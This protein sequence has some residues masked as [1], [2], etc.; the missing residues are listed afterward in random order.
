MDVVDLSTSVYLQIDNRRMNA[1]KVIASH[2][3]QSLEW[4]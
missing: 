4:I 1:K 3:R 2:V